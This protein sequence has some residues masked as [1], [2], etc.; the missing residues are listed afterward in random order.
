MRLLFVLVLLI[1]LN[2]LEAQ[3]TEIIGYW[4][5]CYTQDS[6]V[7]AEYTA[8]ISFTENEMQSAIFMKGPDEEPSKFG[9]VGHYILEENILVVSSDKD[10]QI[11]RYELEFKDD[12]LTM[13]Y[14]P[15]GTKI[16]LKRSAI[17]N[18]P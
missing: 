12:R 11:D 7:E 6:C 17:V 3:R 9:A 16:Y 8:Y 2:T 18:K 4:I 15:Y 13:T 5:P 10:D 14:L 1:S